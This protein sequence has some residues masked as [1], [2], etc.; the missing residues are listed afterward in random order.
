MSSSFLARLSCCGRRLRGPELA[1]GLPD[2]LEDLLDVRLQCLLQGAELLLERGLEPLGLVEGGLGL[3]CSR[4]WRRRLRCARPGP[5]P[6]G[7]GWGARCAGRS[8]RSRTRRR[9]W[10]SRRP[11][12]SVGMRRS[13][14]GWRSWRVLASASAIAC[15]PV[16]GGSTSSLRHGEQRRLRPAASPPSRRPGVGQLAA[17]AAEVVE[18]RGRSRPGRRRRSSSAAVG[19]E[20]VLFGQAGAAAAGPVGRADVLGGRL[21]PGADVD[22]VAELGLG[23]DDGA[24]WRTRRIGRPRLGR[25][26]EDVVDAA[27]AGRAGMSD[28][29]AMMSSARVMERSTATMTSAGTC[30]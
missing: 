29:D 7:P 16:P 23:G 2:L 5:L 13:A 1:F 4:R 15:P 8:R 19:D 20:L 3:A 12:E 18:Q 28:P 10:R 6:P 21:R 25:I 24:G 27:G 17:G 11:L 9:P 14:A 26:A 22:A 30:S